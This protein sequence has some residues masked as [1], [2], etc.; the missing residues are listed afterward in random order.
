M[1]GNMA[2]ETIL[3]YLEASISFNTLGVYIH[4]SSATSAL[5]SMS[6]SQR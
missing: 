6:V 1:N 2:R 3:K 4:S 5:V